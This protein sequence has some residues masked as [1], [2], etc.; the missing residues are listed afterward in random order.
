MDGTSRARPL[1]SALTGSVLALVIAA[2]ASGFFLHPGALGGHDW[3][4]MEAHRVF[5]VKAIRE[6]GQFPF[7]DPYGCGGYPAWGS[8]ESATVVVSPLLAA[9]LTLPLGDAIRVE[10]VTLVVALVLGVHFFARRYVSHPLALGFA[11]LVGALNSRTALQAA[12]GHTWHLAY[13]G[14]P[15]VLGAFD[16]AT[17]R[18]RDAIDGPIDWAWVAFGAAVMA[19]MMYAGGVYPV[20]HAVLCL[21]GLAAYR[22]WVQRSARPIAVAAAMGA[23]AGLLA[24]PKMLPVADTMRRFPRLTQSRE[25]VEPLEWLRMFVSSV[26]G[27]P[28]HHAMGLD[29]MWHEYGQYIGVLPLALVLWGTLR[30]L[31]AEPALRSLRAVGWALMVLALGGWGPWVLLH[32]LPP[33]R[34][35]H[36]PTRFTYPALMLLAVVA[37]SEA[38]RMAPAWRA[39]WERTWGCALGGRSWG[40]RSG[41]GRSRGGRSRGGRPWRPRF[42]AVVWAAFLVC[43]ALVAREDMRA[44]APWFAMPVPA[45]AEHVGGYAQTIEVPAE[46]AYGNGHVET[47]LGMNG[48]PGLLLHEANMGALSCNSFSGLNQDAPRGPNGRCLHLGARGIGDPL[49]RGEAWAEAAQGTTVAIDRWS[50][51]E[52]TVTVDGGQPGSLV[53]LNQNWDPGWTANGVAAIDRDDVAAYRLTAASEKVV[54]RYRPRSLT[55]GLGLLAGGVLLL[56]PVAWSGRR[57]RRRAGEALARAGGCG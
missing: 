18:P 43:A 40:G 16:R 23:W 14:L 50:P 37:A 20:P 10:V 7:W 11:C 22:A 49:Y 2:L 17:A 55:A 15:W 57:R 1:A 47:P 12:V 32:M 36:V 45:V 56:L 48:V 25:T 44:T 3:D 13:A 28:D 21:G 4:Q 26:D 41:G 31:P 39:A 35:Q 8:P 19:L 42:D 5:V 54:F 30:K 51:G 52:V 27:V 33:F 34:S 46:Y 6:F 29:Y 9:Y 53:V 24:A 38:E